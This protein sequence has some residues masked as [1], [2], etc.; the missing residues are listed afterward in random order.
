MENEYLSNVKIGLLE[1]YCK[2]DLSERLYENFDI[3]GNNLEL[4]YYW[5]ERK[6]FIDGLPFAIVLL[7][8]FINIIIQKLFQGIF[9]LLIR[10]SEIWKSSEPI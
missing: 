5:F 1:C 9:I 8:M 7:I 4:C 2:E 3:N 6:I 10:F